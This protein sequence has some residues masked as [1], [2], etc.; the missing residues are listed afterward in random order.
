MIACL[1]S[2]AMSCLNKIEHRR[3]VFNGGY[4]G[5]WYSP[6]DESVA[7][8]GTF[9]DSSILDVHKAI[10]DVNKLAKGSQ[11]FLGGFKVVWVN[12]DG[13][14][15]EESAGIGGSSADELIGTII[16]FCTILYIILAA[17]PSRGL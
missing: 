8:S 1:S 11:K 6:E 15:F 2:C 3:G 7:I 10:I 12:P 4:G 17:T 14:V 13:H 9:K 16:E 5:V